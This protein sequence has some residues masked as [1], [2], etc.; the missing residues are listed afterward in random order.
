MNLFWGPKVLTAMIAIDDNELRN[1][2]SIYRAV[3][4]RSV[5]KAHKV[6]KTMRQTNRFGEKI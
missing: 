4:A 1:T 5:E 2:V 3:L 6:N